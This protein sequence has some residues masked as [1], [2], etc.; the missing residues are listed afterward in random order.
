MNTNVEQ[1]YFVLYVKYNMYKLNINF[2]P[3]HCMLSVTDK[4][5]NI[6][7]V[8]KLLSLRPSPHYL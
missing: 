1:L 4:L 3:K 2:L 5:G 8:N 6:N 7:T